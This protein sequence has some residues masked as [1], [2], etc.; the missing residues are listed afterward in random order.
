MG[1]ITFSLKAPPSGKGEVTQ[2]PPRDPWMAWGD[3]PENR[4]RGEEKLV[5][6]KSFSLRFFL[7]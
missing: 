4:Q 5:L 6:L 3:P 1:G 2:W 7:K